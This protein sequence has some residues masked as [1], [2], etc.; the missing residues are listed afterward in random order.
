M[1][2]VKQA[3]VRAGR[4]SPTQLAQNF[5]EA[6]PPL[7]PVQAGIEA[8]R[9]YYCF[10]A[11]CTTACPTGIDIPT[12][13]RRIADGNLRGAAHTILEEN[14]LGGMCSRVCP[15][16]V[17]CEQACVRNANED[18]PVEIGLLQRHATD[19]FFASS[20]KPL[21]VRAT[22]S[23]RRIAV[24]GAGPAGLTCAYRLALLGH[25][26]TLFDARPKLGGLN[27][28]GLAAY[29]TVGNFAQQEIDWLLSVGGITVRCGQSLGRDIHLQQLR[30]DFDAVF[31]GLGLAGVN[32]LGLSGGAV[33]GLR[34]AVD[35][36]AELRQSSDYAQIAVGRRVVVVG[37]G[38]T[39][40]DAAVQCRKLGAE[41][42]SIVYRRGPE[43][44]SASAHEQSWA[45]DNGV[46]ILHWAAPMALVTEGGAV[47]G[48]EFA[49]TTLKEGRLVQTG[50]SFTL[51]ADWVL[52]AI[53]QSFVA[54]V[55]ED[56]G[57][58][59]EGGRIKTDAN[60]RSSLAKVWAGGDARHGGLDLTVEAVQ[61]GKLAAADI[62]AQLRAA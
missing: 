29:K 55:L 28:Y 44:M 9:C 62:D 21:F 50:E 25:D 30:K 6:H 27:E 26:V 59:L 4:L 60:G 22:S 17:L 52:S 20:G 37:G 57:V 36:I 3:D 38:M 54:G 15:T 7:N 39:A 49:C 14:P 19:A 48:I 12:F 45:K 35:F 53:G 61:H 10:D 34:A 5:C 1:S 56:S 32:E 46:R 43:A 42:V 24:V 13:I 33:P 16:E 11:P 47:R 40:V 23:G 31:L 2:E 18:K 58:A 8:E 41:D 51:T